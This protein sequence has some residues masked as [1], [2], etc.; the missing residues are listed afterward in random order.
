MLFKHSLR[1][2]AQCG[3]SEGGIP[4]EDDASDKPQSSEPPAD[5]TGGSTGSN[6]EQELSADGQASVKDGDEENKHGVER[7]GRPLEPYEVPSFGHPF[8]CHDDRYVAS[9]RGRGRGR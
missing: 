5:A 6:H 7:P 2:D 4:Q 8:F 9:T 3:G 1:A